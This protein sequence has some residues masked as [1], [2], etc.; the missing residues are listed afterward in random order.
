MRRKKGSMKVKCSWNT[1]YKAGKIFKIS[2]SK[3]RIIIVIRKNQSE[4]GIRWI[5]FLWNPHSN[6]GDDF[7]RF[8]MFG[9][10]WDL[11]DKKE[12]L[13]EVITMINW[14]N[15]VSLFKKNGNWYDK[16]Y[17]LREMKFQ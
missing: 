17:K 11:G 5:E 8:W 9:F 2:E 1:L 10:F 12:W 13:L 16:V 15:A 14:V 6:K 4:K 7:S 3:I